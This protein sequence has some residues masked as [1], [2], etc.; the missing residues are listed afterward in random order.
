MIVLRPAYRFCAIAL[1]LVFLALAA[2]SSAQDA[3]D[4][5]IWEKTATRAEAALE[6]GTA[7]D[8]A[9]ESLRSVLAIWRERFLLAQGQNAERIQTLQTQINTLGPEPNRDAGDAPESEELSERRQTLTDQLTRLR[10]PGVAAEEAHSRADGLIREIDNLIRSRRTDRL[11]QLGPSP[12]NF[13]RWPTIADELGR[14]RRDIA[15]D[16]RRAWRSD[17]EQKELRNNL[18]IVLLLLA[19]GTVLIL[20]GRHWVTRLVRA[21]RART[22]PGSGVWSFLVSLGQILIPLSGLYLV[23]SATQATGMIG[24]R[25]APLIDG[26]PGW[27]AVILLTWWLGDQV[28]SRASHIATV[29]LEAPRRAEARILTVLLGIC[30][31]VHGFVWTLSDIGFYTD[32]TRYSLDF[33]VLILAGL[34]LF[35]IGQLL[36]SIGKL[37]ADEGETEQAFARRLAWIL[38]RGA[39]GIGLVGP[40]LGVVGYGAAANSAVYPAIGTLMLMGLVTVLQRLA[41]DIYFLFT[42]QR[43][44]EQRGLIPVLAGFA[45]TLCALPFLALIWGAR[46]A[47]LT[48]LWAQ[49]R[50]G[51]AIGDSR[52]SPS[53]FLTFVIIFVIG[54]MLTRLLQGALRSSVLPKTRMDAGAQTAILSGIGYVGIFAAALIAITG[55][56]IDL[57]ALGYVAGALSVGIGFGLQ[58]IVSNFVS[59]IILL[60]ERPIAKGDWIEV[61]G[62]MGYV[63]DI[64]VRAT[65]IETF[66]R[67]DV[68]VPNSDFISGTVTNYTRGN[69]I[70]RVIAPVGVAYGT[71]T[72]R[73]EAILDEIANAHPMILAT[74]PPTVVFRGFGA[75][76]LD[77]EIRAI[78]RDVNWVLSVH[79]DL[80]HEIAKRFTAEG[81]EIPFAQRDV[82]LRNPETLRGGEPPEP[83]KTDSTVQSTYQSKGAPDA[84]DEDA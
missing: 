29:R 34:A 6:S 84:P 74:P 70:G 83:P 59:G 43:D 40:V 65:R 75:D 7:S 39:M 42:G 48:E 56:G 36:A 60:I 62:Q 25:L 54:Y 71:D 80:N 72:K 11:L 41:Y 78:L 49:F 35:R 20:R 14:T 55:A 67:T 32:A 73:V 44:G 52:F 8:Q 18:P 4:Y 76:S 33:P 30:L 46:V 45:L 19:L 69:T 24:S 51:F 16:F 12:L 61:G 21:L 10:A 9:L 82:W 77:F 2:P 27:G 79:S 17:T 64:S 37:T 38:G 26:L 47:D 3:I 22:R 15:G 63:R 68:I 57:T 23:I 66:D 1:A 13:A 28:F 81:I 5:D 53:D 31:A 58:N 50:E